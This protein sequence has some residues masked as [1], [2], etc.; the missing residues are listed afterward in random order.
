VKLSKDSGIYI[1]TGYSAYD[2]I[3]FIRALLKK[4]DLN[5]D[6]DFVYSAMTT[7]QDGEEQEDVF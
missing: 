5:I 2:C 3:C 7:K 1:S 4:Y 6:E